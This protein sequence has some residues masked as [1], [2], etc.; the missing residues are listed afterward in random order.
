FPIRSRDTWTGSAIHCL[1]LAHRVLNSDP[2]HVRRS[3]NRLV[4]PVLPRN[5]V[6][7]SRALPTPSEI[8]PDTADQPLRHAPDTHALASENPL[9]ILDQFLVM[10]RTAN[11]IGP[12]KIARIVGQFFLSHPRAVPNALGSVVV[13]NGIRVWVNQLRAAKNPSFNALAV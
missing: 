3:L 11:P 8:H 13:K 5:P 9:V 4:M 12:V 6:I 10:A 2:A 7:L 1:T